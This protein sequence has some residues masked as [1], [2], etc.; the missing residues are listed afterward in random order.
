[1]TLP[2]IISPKKF[3]KDGN[4]LKGFFEPSQFNRINSLDHKLIGKVKLNICFYQESGNKISVEGSSVCLMRF[5]CQRCLNYFDQKVHL[6]IN[7]VL[8]ED[9]LASEDGRHDNEEWILEAGELN[10]LKA[11]EDELLLMMPISP[12]HGLDE[13]EHDTMSGILEAGNSN[14]S[15]FQVLRK[16]KTKEN[17]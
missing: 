9:D 11:L 3:T 10:I 4:K 17:K 16:F 6:D 15:P 2:A 7:T 12:L 14:N 5:V 13:C 8:V 1:M